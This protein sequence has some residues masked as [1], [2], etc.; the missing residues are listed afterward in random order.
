MGGSGGFFQVFV[1]DGIID[2]NP[3]NAKGK[4]EQKKPQ[5]EGAGKMFAKRFFQDNCGNAAK[6]QS[7]ADAKEDLKKKKSINVRWQKKTCVDAKSQCEG[8]PDKVSV[9]DG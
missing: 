1:L 5:K 2:I 4:G 6:Q 7:Y 8:Q 9:A 3:S